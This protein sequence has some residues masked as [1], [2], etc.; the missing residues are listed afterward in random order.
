MYKY[1]E[2]Q[3]LRG[4]SH[5]RFQLRA[6]LEVIPLQLNTRALVTIPRLLTIAPASCKPP[7]FSLVRFI[8]R[9]IW[10]Y[11][12]KETD[13]LRKL[14]T[15]HRL[16]ALWNPSVFA[17]PL[18]ISAKMNVLRG[19]KKDDED[20]KCQPGSWLASQR[21]ISLFGCWPLFKSLV[22]FLAGSNPFLHLEKSSV[23]QEVIKPQNSSQIVMI[24]HSLHVIGTLLQRQPDQC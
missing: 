4:Q 2:R 20:C 6:E 8:W 5:H 11:T 23:L 18:S 14:P 3:D 15:W 17:T 24:P 12:T 13:G 1:Q 10:K 16:V 19:Y 22:L 21:T 7:W 9:V